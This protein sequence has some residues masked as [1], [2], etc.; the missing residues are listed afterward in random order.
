HGGAVLV[1][2]RVVLEPLSVIEHQHARSRESSNDWF[3]HLLARAQ[4][5]DTRDL[6]QRVRERHLVSA[7]QLLTRELWGRQRRGERAKRGPSGGDRD[8]TQVQRAGSQHESQ[9][10]AR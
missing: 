9:R 6:V 10:R 3:A 2:P 1:T 5:T 7:P 4:R 8:R